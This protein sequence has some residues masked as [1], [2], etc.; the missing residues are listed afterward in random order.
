[1]EGTVVLDQAPISCRCLP[2]S[3]SWPDRVRSQVHQR[4]CAR[5]HTSTIALRRLEEPVEQATDGL[6]L[7]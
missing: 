5:A 2:V 1:M 6:G 7:E 3:G 4:C